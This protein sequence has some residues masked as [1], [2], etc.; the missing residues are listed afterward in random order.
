[1][2]LETALNIKSYQGMKPLTITD[3]YLQGIHSSN[4]TGD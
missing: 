2:P 1:M 4:L 3:N